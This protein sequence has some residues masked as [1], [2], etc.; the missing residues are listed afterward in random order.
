MGSDFDLT[1]M[2]D[3]ESLDSYSHP[4]SG[5]YHLG[6]ES[7][8][9]SRE[10]GEF[11]RVKFQVLNG[12]VE[13]QAKRTFSERFQ[14]PSE[15]HKDG[16][17]FCRKRRAKLG[18]ATGLIKATDL[19]KKISIDWQDLVGRQLVAAVEEYKDANEE[20]K[21][22]YRGAQIIRL[23]MWHVRDKAVQNVPKDQ[24]ALALLD[25]DDDAGA[26]VDAPKSPTPAPASSAA[27]T[28]SSEAYSK[29]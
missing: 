22:Q 19:G 14:D 23:E 7:V 21:K 9:E 29:L 24:E 10:H 11:F 15:S 28:A 27:P 5:V 2:P 8:D 13:G 4:K 6:I 1:D 12:T 18:L 26:P 20:T 3:E 17:L 16:G 25:D